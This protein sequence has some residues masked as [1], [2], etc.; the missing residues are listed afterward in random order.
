[1]A[2]PK[3]MIVIF[4]LLLLLRN[5]SLPRIAREARESLSYVLF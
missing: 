2:E 3:S 4:L 5:C 1:M